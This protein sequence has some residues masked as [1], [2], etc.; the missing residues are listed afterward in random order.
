LVFP[1]KP[2]G[3]WKVNP[4][5]LLVRGILKTCWLEEKVVY[6]FPKLLLF[7]KPVGI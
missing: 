7:Q 6:D 3:F 2:V 5:N 1:S 4:Q